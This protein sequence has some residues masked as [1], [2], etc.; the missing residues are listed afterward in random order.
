MN[1]FEQT[2]DFYGARWFAGM[3]LAYPQRWRRFRGEANSATLLKRGPTPE[4]VA[5]I[6]SGGGSDGPLLPAFVGEGL[7]DACVIGAPYS[8]PNAY[9]LYEAGLHL[10]KEKGVLLMYNNF[11]GDFLNNDMAAELLG[12][13]GI[14]VESVAATDDMGMAVGEPRENRGGRCSLPLLIKL[15]AGAAKDGLSLADT[16][17]LVRRANARS[18]TLCVVVDQQREE[19]SYGNGFSGEP[20]FRRETHMDPGRTARE[21]AEMVLEDLR[22]REGEKLYV[23]LNRLRLTSYADSY[24]MALRIHEHLSSRHEVAQLRVGGFSNILDVYGYTLTLLCADSAME[25]YLEG[26]IGGDSF[27]L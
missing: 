25:K 17:A 2:R 8:A 22:P 6:I 7:A 13:E 20:G 23:L 27:M 5:V 3:E 21:L 4:R 10:G 24:N 18:A 26:T 19:I 15:A 1:W 16:A 11:A 12:L 14:G 9:A